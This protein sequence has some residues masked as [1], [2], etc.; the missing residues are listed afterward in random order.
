MGRRKASKD[1]WATET[2]MEETGI[3]VETT[4]T[5]R[6]DGEKDDFGGYDND[7]RTQRREDDNV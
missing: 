6:E 3:R 1:P 4:L 7:R 2:K 5:Q